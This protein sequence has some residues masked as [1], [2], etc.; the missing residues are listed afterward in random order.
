MAAR[1][2]QDE[3]AD[4]HDETGQFR[5]RQEFVGEDHSPCGVEP[6]NEQLDRLHFAGTEHDDW[7]VVHDELRRVG[8]QGS[9]HLHLEFNRARLGLSMPF[10]KTTARPLPLSF[11]TY[12]ATSASRS[13]SEAP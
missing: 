10:E 1:F 9:Q 12:M 7:L 3:V 8:F 2:A 5:H 4:R 6:A 11:A 13:V